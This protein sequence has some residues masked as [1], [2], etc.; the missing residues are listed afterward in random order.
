M[1]FVPAGAE[2][3]DPEE[4]ADPDV[5]TFK[6]GEL[7]LSGELRDG[8]EREKGILLLGAC[9]IACR[10]VPLRSHHQKGNAM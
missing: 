5:V 6:G 8:S 1:T 4:D 3:V 7:D 10:I 2:D 9:H